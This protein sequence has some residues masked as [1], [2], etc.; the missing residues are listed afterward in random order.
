MPSAL[1]GTRGAARS[2]PPVRTRSREA[3]SDEATVRSHTPRPQAHI[4]Q[5]GY[6]VIGISAPTSS[7]L[8]C[9]LYFTERGYHTGISDDTRHSNHKTQQP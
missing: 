4:K 5:D 3:S 6:E 2:V 7:F 1:N 8:S 9:Y